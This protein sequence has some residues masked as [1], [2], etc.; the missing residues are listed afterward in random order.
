MA[1]ACTIRYFLWATDSFSVAKGINIWNTDPIA[2][3]ESTT[4]RFAVRPGVGVAS[5]T[6]PSLPVEYG[7]EVKP[8]PMRERTEI[9]CSL[10]RQAWVSLGIY[11][12][13][14]QK[15]A[16]LSDGERFAGSEFFLWD[17]RDDA[18]RPA[19]NGVYFCRLEARERG[20]P[21]FNAT[22]RITVLR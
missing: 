4:F 3:P 7:L 10:P 15:I 18:G 20:Q 1:Q 19:G 6:N 16:S 22:R 8:N 11:N 5:G 13:L 9:R 12:S 17:G 14:G 2:S 21:A